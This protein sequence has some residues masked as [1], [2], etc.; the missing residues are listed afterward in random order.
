MSH[1]KKAYAAAFLYAVIIGF[2]LIFV[3]FAL[4]SAHPIDLLAHRFTL[5]FAA[6]AAVV[7]LRRSKLRLSGK[8]MLAMLPLAVFFP[9]LYFA[10]QTFGLLY[11][12]SSEAGI[13]QAT[14]PLMTMLLASYWIKEASTFKQKIGIALSVAGVVYMIAMKGIHMNAANL[15]GAL[16]ILLSSLSFAVYNV[17]GRKLVQQYSAADITFFIMGVSFVVFNGFAIGRHAAEGTLTSFFTPFVDPLFIASILYL[18]ILSSLITSLLTNYALTYMEASKMSVFINLA[19]FITV[20][21]GV[22]VFGEKLLPAHITGGLVILAGV[23]IV[24]IS[25]KPTRKLSETNR[26]SD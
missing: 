10:L 2:S 26:R 1:L 22:A 6:A 25:G 15:N 7:L 19:T 17:L 16:L 23:M 18:G 8:D 14:I 13:I 5:S 11:I 21:A 9:T 24:N 12:P 3:K 20:I 4:I